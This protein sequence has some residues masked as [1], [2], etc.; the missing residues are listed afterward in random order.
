MMASSPAEMFKES[1]SWGRCRAY[2]KELSVSIEQ[3]RSE[4][5]ALAR[6]RGL[7]IRTMLEDGGHVLF[8]YSPDWEPTELQQAGYERMVASYFAEPGRSPEMTWREA[9]DIERRERIRAVP[10]TD[11]PVVLPHGRFPLLP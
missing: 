5:R 10:P 8:A 4:L 9:V 3:A 11:Q 2:D 6:A 7:S 1:L